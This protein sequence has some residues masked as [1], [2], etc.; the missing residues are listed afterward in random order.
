MQSNGALAFIGL[1]ILIVGIV[2]LAT[3]FYLKTRDEEAEAEAKTESKGIILIGPFP[4]VWG[5][6]PKGKLVALGAVIVL[7]L[8]WLLMYYW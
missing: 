7:I 8:I 5:F 1:I 3:G 2:M 4:I 6:G